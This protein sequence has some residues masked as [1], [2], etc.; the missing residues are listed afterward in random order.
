MQELTFD[1]KKVWNPPCFTYS[2]DRQVD[3]SKMEPRVGC[4]LY[5]MEW[6]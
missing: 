4:E 2:Y 1:H 3:A 5:V 6:L